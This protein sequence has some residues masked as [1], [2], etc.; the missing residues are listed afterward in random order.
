[1]F[2]VDIIR[3]LFKSE[4]KKIVELHNLNDEKH[5]DTSRTG[6]Q[7]LIRLCCAIHSNGCRIGFHVLF[8]NRIILN[9]LYLIYTILS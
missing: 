4:D 6:E 1:M 8:E 9:G 2:C 7:T 5:L 3:L